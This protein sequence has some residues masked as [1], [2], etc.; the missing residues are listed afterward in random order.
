MQHDSNIYFL[1]SSLSAN[2]TFA[3]NRNVTVHN[4]FPFNIHANAITTSTP[5]IHGAQCDVLQWKVT[6][7]SGTA[8]KRVKSFEVRHL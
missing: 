6:L 2:V 3:D 1:N 4:L 8:S 7:R 5:P